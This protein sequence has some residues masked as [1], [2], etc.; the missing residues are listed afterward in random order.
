M[1]IE[2]YADGNACIYSI[3]VLSKG[4]SISLITSDLLEGLSSST[5][6]L[7]FNIFPT[8]VKLSV[9]VQSWIW[10]TP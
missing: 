1:F 9:L 4:P 7:A 3:K 6:S 2:A 8:A 5:Q 10:F